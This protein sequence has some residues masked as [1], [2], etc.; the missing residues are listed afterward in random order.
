[1]AFQFL[2]ALGNV[3]SGIAGVSGTSD[4]RIA[5]A[6]QAQGF[7]PSSP[8][9]RAWAKIP[10][11]LSPKQLQT[12]YESWV[13]P[14][15]EFFVQQQQLL[16]K[17]IQGY[18]ESVRS[19]APLLTKSVDPP[20]VATPVAKAAPNMPSIPLTPEGD[21]A[22]AALARRRGGAAGAAAW[23]AG[24]QD[25]ALGAVFG[26]ISRA[27][28]GITGGVANVT[29]N[30]AGGAANIVAGTVGPVVDL[31]NQIVPI[32]APFIGGGGGGGMNPQ[33]QGPGNAIPA[34]GYS[35]QSPPPRGATGAPG[36]YAT[37]ASAVDQL[38]GAMGGVLSVASPHRMQ[39]SGRY[40]AQ[41]HLVANPGTG[42][43]EWFGPY[44]QPKTW[45]KV[46]VR[47]RR[48]RPR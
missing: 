39:P 22:R 25:M 43:L 36:V 24:G 34:G 38:Q 31:A 27:I 1:M 2:G 47:K 15:A 14:Q 29:G 5:L 41:P 46:T 17:G 28:Q 6:I 23:N 35:L 13:Q 44:G 4:P 7:D 21:A 12:F 9:G 40:V 48:C 8:A 10:Q 33:G 19:I 18:N 20:P 45:S 37:P 11:R 42:R 30:L 26:G 3:L 32:T 16:A